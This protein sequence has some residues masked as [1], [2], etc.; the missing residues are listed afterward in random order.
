MEVFFKN[1]ETGVVYCAGPGMDQPNMKPCDKDGNLLY[2][3]TPEQPQAAAAVEIDSA[4]VVA[5]ATDVNT[6]AQAAAE[7][8]EADAAAAVDQAEADESANAEAQQS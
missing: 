8:A 5:A 3:D 6:E 1:I 4:A 7:N 2:Q